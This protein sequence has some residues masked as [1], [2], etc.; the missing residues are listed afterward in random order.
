M[1]G[2]MLWIVSAVQALVVM[3]GLYHGFIS[4]FGIFPQRRK[5]LHQPEKHFAIIIPA[6]NEEIVIEELIHSLYRQDYPRELY[7]VM[8]ICDNCTDGT[9]DVVRANGAAAFIRRNSAQAG[10]GYA[11][12]W[13]L[14]QIYDMETKFD[15]VV[16]LDADNVVSSN[17]LAHMNDMLLKGHKIVQGYLDSKNPDDSWVSISYAIAYW[18]MGRMWQLARYRLGLPNALGGTGMCIEIETLKKLGWDTYSLTEDLEFT[19]K[20]VL[21]GI[22]PVWAH[23]AK[24]YDEKPVQFQAS[25]QQ[26]LRWM[27]GHWDVAIRYAGPMLKRLVLYRD[28][29]ALD[30]LIYLLQP[31]RI[32]LA[33][34]TLAVN[35]ILSFT[36]YI[37]IFKWLHAA[38]FFPRYIWLSLFIM[39][40][41]LPPSVAL[42]IMLERVKLGRFLGLLWYQFFGLSWLPLTVLGL[43]THKNKA[44]SHTVH[45]KKIDITLLESNKNGQITDICNVTVSSTN[46]T[47]N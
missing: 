14:Q 11:I 44:W 27:Q 7:S 32:L 36:P 30:S 12:Q 28:L 31:S 23:Q 33:Y 43:F 17:F 34:F 35:V 41:L 22:K 39:Q 38:V 21:N 9:A 10:K 20:A 25:W 24:V 5:E 3:F 6:H 42:I 13:M 4:L 40:W 18:Y 1:T 16:I 19:M 37:F 2:V 15:A 26:R 45:T 46:K 8:V 29:C 47:V